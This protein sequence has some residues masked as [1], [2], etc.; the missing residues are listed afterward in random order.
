MPRFSFFALILA[1]LLTAAGSAAARTVHLT[2]L[3]SGDTY[4]EI[5]PCP[6]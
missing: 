4:G 2:I 6:T 3:F 5:A 1:L